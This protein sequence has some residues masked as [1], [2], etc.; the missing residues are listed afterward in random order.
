MTKVWKGRSDGDRSVLG[1]SSSLWSKMMERC[2]PC[3]LPR[4][5]C[6][7]SVSSSTN[8]RVTEWFPL[9]SLKRN[10]ISV[11]SWRI[12]SCAGGGEIERNQPRWRGRWSWNLA[13]LAT[14]SKWN[15]VNGSL[16]KCTCCFF[17]QGT[18]YLWSSPRVQIGDKKMWTLLE[19]WT[20]TLEHWSC[21]HAEINY[22][23]LIRERC[24]PKIFV[25]WHFFKKD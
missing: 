21:G 3:A 1:G 17:Y 19:H 5:I 2:L 14:T 20:L 24:Q 18:K 4:I 8:M 25:T 10:F 16:Y 7:R 13:L 22:F 12:V 15:I 11:A 23:R 6:R 9:E